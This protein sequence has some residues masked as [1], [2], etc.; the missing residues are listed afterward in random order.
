MAAVKKAG[1]NLI[2][3]SDISNSGTL[4]WY[5]SL[6]NKWSLSDIKSTPVGMF[7]T[8][9]C[10]WVMETLKLC[11]QGSLKVHN[12]LVKGAEALVK[13]GEE[14]IFAPAYLVVAEKPLE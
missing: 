10:L 3:A 7:V 12:L 2:E 14:G 1:F 4:P 5:Y 13:G 11:P 6:Q 8:Q 9:C